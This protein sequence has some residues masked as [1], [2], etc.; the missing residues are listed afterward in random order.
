MSEIHNSTLKQ[1]FD[2]PE[3]LEKNEP[4]LYAE[5][6]DIFVDHHNQETQ[7]HKCR[8][9]GHATILRKGEQHHCAGCLENGQLTAVEWL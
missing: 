1:F 3:E 5:A 8:F 7:E 9:C 2:K 6:V 4:E